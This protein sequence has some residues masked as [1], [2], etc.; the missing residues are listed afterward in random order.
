MSPAKLSAMKA[1]PWEGISPGRILEVLIVTT[2]PALCLSGGQRM[3]L[4]W[5]C[6]SLAAV[7]R[8]VQQLLRLKKN[9]LWNWSLWN[10]RLLAWKH[11]Q[12]PRVD[13]SWGHFHAN[14]AVLMQNAHL[15][16]KN[17]SPRFIPSVQ[18]TVGGAWWS[19]SALR[20]GVPTSRWLLKPSYPPLILCGIVWTPKLSFLS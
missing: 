19:V 15:L 12:D 17:T 2:E 7:T 16:V 3:F 11:N 8:Q 4:H 20:R 6:N 1:L 9:F 10:W 14:S 5:T 13:V 18:V